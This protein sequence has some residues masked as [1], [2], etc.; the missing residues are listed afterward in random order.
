MGGLLPSHILHSVSL[1]ARRAAAQES[2]FNLSYYLS[3]YPQGQLGRDNDI[4]IGGV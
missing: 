1:A 3:Q 2:I 4:R